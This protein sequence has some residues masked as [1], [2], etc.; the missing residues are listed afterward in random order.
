[1][2]TSYRH[3]RST[4]DVLEA[5]GGTTFEGIVWRVTRSERDA[6]RGSS[7]NGRWSG[8]GEPEVLYT[9]L[10]KHGALAEIGFRLAAEPIWPSRIRHSIHSIQA[11]AAN[12][13][14]IGKFETLQK[15]GVDVSAYGSFDYAFTQAIA[16]AANFLEFGG[17]IAPSARADCNNAV[18]FVER[19]IE[20]EV[21]SPEEI[22]W[23]GWRKDRSRQR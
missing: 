23:D 10:E 6:L 20:L 11:K 14:D 7:A 8:N 15:L 22:D 17:L 5:L 9:S 13:V 4:L 2:T 21:A 16:A 12:I 19:N 1:M 18:F 3:D